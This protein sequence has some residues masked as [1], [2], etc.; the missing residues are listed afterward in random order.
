M[1]Q[2]WNG[3][4]EVPNKVRQKI[5]TNWHT[6]GVGVGKKKKDTTLYALLFSSIVQGTRIV[7]TT[8]GSNGRQRTKEAAQ[9]DGG[10]GA[11]FCGPHLKA[12]PSWLGKGEEYT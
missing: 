9:G 6:M 3:K 2:I 8:R 12:L 11:P 7:A 4:E 1:A 10:P 5:S